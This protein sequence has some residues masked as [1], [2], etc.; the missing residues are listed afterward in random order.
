MLKIQTLL[1]LAR[2]IQV[3]LYELLKHR[4]SRGVDSCISTWIVE[5]NLFC[6]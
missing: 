5:K 4:F 3:L 6:I 2:K 1:L